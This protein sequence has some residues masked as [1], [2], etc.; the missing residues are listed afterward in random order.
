MLLPILK[1][2]NTHAAIF[3]LWSTHISLT[4]SD[5]V[6]FWVVQ[7]ELSCVVFLGVSRTPSLNLHL[8]VVDTLALLLLHTACIDRYDPT[9]QFTTCWDVEFCQWLYLLQ[10]I[11]L[12]TYM[13]QAH[14]QSR[15]GNLATPVVAMT[16][17]NVPIAFP[18]AIP[19]PFQS[20]FIYIHCCA[21]ISRVW[22]YFWFHASSAEVHLELHCWCGL[23]VGNSTVPRMDCL[24]IVG[25]ATLLITLACYCYCKSIIIFMIP[26]AIIKFVKYWGE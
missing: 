23:L 18:T 10:V 3:Y 25:Y 14:I 15:M 5:R 21:P 26:L 16:T 2:W 6:V 1:F 9:N 19:S 24:I 22:R 8:V 4:E 13:L 17:P 7:V 11:Y 20:E 12:S